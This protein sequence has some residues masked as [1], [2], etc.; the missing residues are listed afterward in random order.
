VALGAS[1]YERHF[2]I[3]DGPEAIDA[4]V[5]S[6]PSQFAA[7]VTAMEQTRIALGDGRKR[8]LPAEAPNIVPSRRGLYATRMLRAGDRITAD[9]VIALRPATPL[10]PADISHLVGTVLGRDVAAGAPFDAQ[11]IAIR[12]AS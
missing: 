6:T 3:E 4:A 12:K 10:A 5:S 9:D 7:I 1:I 2:M 8:C 11:D